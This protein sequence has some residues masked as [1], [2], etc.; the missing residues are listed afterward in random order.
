MYQWRSWSCRRKKIPSGR[1]KFE[2]FHI[3][4][5]RPFILDTGPTWKRPCSVYGN[6]GCLDLPVHTWSLSS[7]WRIVVCLQRM[8]IEHCWFYRHIEGIHWQ[9]FFHACTSK[10]WWCCHHWQ[11]MITRSRLH[12]LWASQMVGAKQYLHQK[13]PQ[14]ASI[15]PP[16]QTPEYRFLWHQSSDYYWERSHLLSWE[17]KRNTRNK[18]SGMADCSS[19]LSCRRGYM[20]KPYS[21]RDDKQMKIRAYCFVLPRK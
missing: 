15:C 19:S 18:W 7:S 9:Y 10:G 6:Q 4:Y 3:G 1:N 11:T 14:S 12:F 8:G 20:V 16:M 2:T 13:Q 17:D 5:L 21:R